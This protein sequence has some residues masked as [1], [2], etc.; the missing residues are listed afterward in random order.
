MEEESPALRCHLR[1]LLHTGFD[2]YHLRDL[3]GSH[4]LVDFVRPTSLICRDCLLMTEMLRVA[5]VQGGHPHRHRNR[6]PELRPP[7][8]IR[9][10][11]RHRPRRIRAPGQYSF[12]LCHHRALAVAEV[13]GQMSG[14]L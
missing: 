14:T 9:A 4:F 3:P 10:P 12:C 7:R 2:V 8:R 5:Q 13:S 1:I 11:E 6:A